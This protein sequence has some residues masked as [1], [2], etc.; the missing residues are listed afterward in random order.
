MVHL[1]ILFVCDCV[2]LQCRV[3]VVVFY[4]MCVVVS[5]KFPGVV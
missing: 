1:V 5:R 3:F 4:G 2:V